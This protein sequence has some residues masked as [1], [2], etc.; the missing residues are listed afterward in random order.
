MTKII[1]VFWKL[2]K[3]SRNVYDTNLI[4]CQHPACHYKFANFIHLN[5]N[6]FLIDAMDGVTGIN[7]IVNCIIELALQNIE[8]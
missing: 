7:K 2:I 4:I 6:L 5:W 1:F 3:I 8:I